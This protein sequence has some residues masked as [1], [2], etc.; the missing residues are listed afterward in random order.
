VGRRPARCRVKADINAFCDRLA[1]KMPKLRPIVYAPEW[2]YGDTLDGLRYPLWA[3]RYVT[4]AGPASKLYPGDSS[5]RWAAYSGQ[6][7]AILQFTSSATIV[8]QT[9]CDAN[10]YRGTLAQLTALIAPGWETD[11]ALT[12]DDISKVAQAVYDLMLTPVDQNDGSGTK[13]T[14]IG[15]QVWNQG[16]PNGVTGTKTNA[17][18]ALRDA[19]AAAQAIRSAVAQPASVDVNALAVALAP[20]LP[21]A[22]VTAAELQDAIV[23]ALKALVDRPAS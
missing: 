11:M 9:T 7:P 18:S 5:P 10:A 22:T 15:Q 17:W 6:T 21:Q 4:G 12:A 23:G 14:P 1:A 16:I 20:L 8:G 3:S 13:S 2:V 19:G